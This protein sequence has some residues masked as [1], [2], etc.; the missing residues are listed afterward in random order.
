MTDW[1]EL[2]KGA[3][4]FFV[5]IGGIS[6][7]G[8]AAMASS[9]GYIVAG[10]D[11]NPGYH[12]EFLARQGILIFAGHQAD[13]IDSFKPDLVIHTAAVHQDNP[14]LIRAGQLGLPVLDRARFL[15]QLNRLFQKVINIAGT[16]GKT[17]TTAI[18]ALIMLAAG[19]DPAVHLGAELRQFGGTIRTSRSN[20]LLISEACE[21]MN[22][23]L[24]FY[25][26][27]A[28]ILNIEYDHVDCFADLDEV[29]SS[30]TSFANLLS[31]DASLVLATGDPASGRM[32][33][34][35]RKIRQE[36]GI[37]LPQLIGFALADETYHLPEDVQ[38]A[39]LYEVRALSYES[40]KPHFEIWYQK[41]FICRT[42][43]GIGGRHNVK[44]AIAAVACAHANGADFGSAARVLAEFQ[45][46]EGRFTDIGT[47]QSARVIADYAHHPAAAKLTLAGARLL[48]H[49]Q[50]LVVF[51]PLT[52]SR[53]KVL[54][55]DYVNA[56]KDSEQI[57]FA[58]IYSD[59]E[60]DPGDISSRMLVDR[61][62][63][64][65]GRAWFGRDLPAIKDWLSHRA[66]PGDLILVMGP[67]NIRNFA[68]S[69]TGR[70]SHLD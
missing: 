58:E 38:L 49:R 29:I 63:Q 65:G 61:I 41:K 14:E 55:D 25:S 9:A 53:T 18:C 32:L 36:A 45:G 69:L 3:R 70:K 35:L 34:N 54:F 11:R 64:L 8:L 13:W 10:S 66:G 67:E 50:L 33:E 60:I 23:Y 15:G 2:K 47:F 5:G 62:N 59:R 22:S 39:A 68:D 17:T 40:G 7:S 20:D 57:I 24:Q 31:P 12:T 51:E 19:L 46:A 16:H 56:L 37:P 30:F 44:N 1:H 6:M 28:A 52:F 42:S 21:Y 27:T 48:P 26:T 43:L 4:L